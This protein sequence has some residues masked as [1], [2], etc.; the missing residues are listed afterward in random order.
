MQEIIRI[1]NEPTFKSV[2]FGDFTFR[3]ATDAD[4]TASEAQV[5]GNLIIEHKVAKTRY[6]F[7]ATG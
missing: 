7:E 3:I 4:V 5:A 2:S 1:G 6:E